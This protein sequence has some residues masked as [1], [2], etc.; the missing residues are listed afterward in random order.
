MRRIR[1]SA[2][3]RSAATDASQQK[4]QRLLAE[5]AVSP[6]TALG[7]RRRAVSSASSAPPGR[8]PQCRTSSRQ[9]ATE[10]AVTLDA[11]R[12][13]GPWVL[14]SG[15][16]AT[17]FT[18]RGALGAPPRPTPRRPDRISPGITWASAP[19]PGVPGRRRCPGRTP[20]AGPP[21]TA[22]LSRRQRMTSVT[23][24]TSAFRRAGALPV[25]IAYA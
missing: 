15:E 13:R 23:S 5:R 20:R 4:R 21:R 7:P 3:T 18:G 16:T 12:E 14:A 10:G 24:I 17:A 2:T 1:Q 9:A 25:S 6:Q 11:G 8:A 22:R 19:A